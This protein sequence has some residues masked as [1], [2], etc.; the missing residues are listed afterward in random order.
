MDGLLDNKAYVA[1][2]LWGGSNVQLLHLPTLKVVSMAT[3]PDTVPRTILMQTLEEQNYLF[4]AL[5]KQG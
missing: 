2:G 4:V 3:I 5:G 1:V